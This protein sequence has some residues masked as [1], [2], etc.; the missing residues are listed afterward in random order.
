MNSDG[1]GRPKSDPNWT[2]FNDRIEEN[3]VREESELFRATRP[4]RIAKRVL[5]I[6]MIHGNARVHDVLT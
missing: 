3:L 6:C 5:I 2:D 1:T 4:L